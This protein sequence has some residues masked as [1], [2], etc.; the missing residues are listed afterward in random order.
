MRHVR[1]FGEVESPEPL[2]LMLVTHYA[3]M[4]AMDRANQE[5]ERSVPDRPPVALLYA[6]LA[7]MSLG[8]HDQFAEVL[9]PPA[10]A[11][12]PDG[13][14]DVLEFLRVES[15]FAEAFEQQVLSTVHGWEQ[16]DDLREIV[17]RIGNRPFPGGRRL[18][19]PSHLCDPEPR[20]LAGLYGRPGPEPGRGRGQPHGHGTQDADSSRDRRLARPVAGYRRAARTLNVGVE[21]AMPTSSNP[22]ATQ[23]ANIQSRTGKTLAELATLVAASGLTRHGEIRDMLK[24]DLGLGHGDAN[25]LVHHVLRSDGGSA[26]AG[27]SDDEVLDE[28]Y[29]GPKAA[30]R[31]VHDAHPD[32]APRRT[33]TSNR[34]QEGLREPAPE[35]AVRDGRTGHQHAAGGG[36]EPEGHRRDPRLEAPESPAG[37]ASSR[38]S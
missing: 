4:A 32:R 25:T 37:C 11:P 3:D 16:Q 2:D 19:L 29:A 23:L 21:V 10:F 20:R 30:L 17:V 38:S 1:V 22:V 36:A 24:R 28:I 26:A 35:E 13:T 12:A 34:P 27:K 6:R 8:H 18:G 14:L 9:S 7:N 15:G 33:A 5:L 31:P